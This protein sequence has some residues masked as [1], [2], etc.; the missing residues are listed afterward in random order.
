MEI[1]YRIDSR[2][3]ITSV[4]PRWLDFATEN[5]APDLT[6]EA[7]IGRPLWDF[8]SGVE[9]RQVYHMLFA[10]VRN[11]RR[12]ASIPF[13]CDSPG[14]RR[15]MEMDLSVLSDHEIRIQARLIR[16][17]ARRMVSFPVSAAT[18]SGGWLRS[19]S[20]C[21]RFHLYQS[22][23]AEIDETVRRLKLLEVEVPP[24]ITYGICPDCERQVRSTIAAARPN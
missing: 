16:S 12:L 17:E 10:T 19:C 21:R 9:V 8:V 6:P 7:V 11:G 14:V 5:G 2:D 13:R 20:W 4:S 22:R 23:W 1:Q 15:F 3:R 18:G 24:S